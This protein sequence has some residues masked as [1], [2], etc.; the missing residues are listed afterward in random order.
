MIKL[1]EL[2]EYARANR[3]NN[4]WAIDSAVSYDVATDRSR[5]PLP[6]IYFD[7]NTTLGV[8]E[9]DFDFLQTFTTTIRARLVCL[10]TQDRTGKQGQ[11]LI[12]YCRLELF[13]ML[14]FKKI[15]KRFNEIYFYGDDFERYDEARY[16]HTFEFRFTGVI[17]KS[18]LDEEDFNE[19]KSLVINYN[20]T[21]ATPV[22]QPNATDKLDTFQD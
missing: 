17:D 22:T 1:T 15:D 20:L 7:I 3:S 5:L 21:D 2:I 4:G 8:V 12:Y 19:L 16:I 14:L 10:S 13:K 11:D 6:A 9:S 18:F